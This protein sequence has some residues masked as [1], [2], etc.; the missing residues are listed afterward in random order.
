MKVWP[1]AMLAFVVVALPV[2]ADD[3]AGTSH[4]L[5]AAI[6]AHRC[7]TDGQCTSA[8]PWAWN[9]PE[10]LEVDLVA[11]K[12]HT[13]AASGENRETPIRSLLRDEGLIVLQGFELGRAFSVLINE[14]T[15]D[16]S[17]A[18]AR[19]NLTVSV[20]GSCTPLPAAR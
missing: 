4:F 15:G 10:F 20:F 9:M 3:L 2:A 13:T 14:A 17:L 8:P 5:C 19:E 7:S 12:I 16:A 1:I 18:V 11:K 6:Q